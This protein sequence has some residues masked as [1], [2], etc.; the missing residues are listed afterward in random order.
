MNDYKECLSEYS[1]YKKSMY[2]SNSLTTMEL[3]EKTIS[4]HFFKKLFLEIKNNFLNK[5]Q[6]KW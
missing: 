2:T 1:K 6:V 4:K 5:L 3:N